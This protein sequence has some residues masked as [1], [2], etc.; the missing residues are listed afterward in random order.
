MTSKDEMTESLRKWLQGA[1]LSSRSIDLLILNGYCAIDLFLV[2]NDNDIEG[3]A[4]DYNIPLI[5]KLKLKL[6][7]RKHNSIQNIPQIL[8]TC[9]NTLLN[10]QQIKKESTT[11]GKKRKL[12]ESSDHKHDNNADQPQQKKMKLII[13]FPKPSSI[14]NSENNKT[15]VNHIITSSRNRQFAIDVNRNQPMDINHKQSCVPENEQEKE[16][17]ISIT[18]LHNTISQNTKKKQALLNSLP[19]PKNDQISTINNNNKDLINSPKQNVNLNNNNDLDLH[20][21][22]SYININDN[23]VYTDYQRIKSMASYALCN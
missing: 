23:N 3:I 1:D 18:S 4:N 16:K 5:D 10:S 22:L 8:A 17:E 2:C 21:R 13:K 9:K 12:D 14:K 7:I 20:R 15:Q 11:N 19:L 6:A